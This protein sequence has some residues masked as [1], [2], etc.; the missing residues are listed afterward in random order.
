M[1]GVF[2]DQSAITPRASEMTEQELQSAIV[3][4]ANWL[5]FKLAYHTHDSTHS[6]AGFP[7][8]VLVNA[9]AQRV[10]FV[11]VKSAKGK[12]SDDQ[13]K[14]YAGLIAAGAEAYVWRPQDWKDGTVEKGLRNV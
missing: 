10:V 7:D 12:L 2:E 5:G 14:W 11:E 8:L 4:M 3:E 9:R 6:A 1:P 13:L